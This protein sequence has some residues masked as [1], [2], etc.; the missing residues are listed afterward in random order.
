M[1][2]AS[3]TRYRFQYA[4]KLIC[5]SNVAG[6]SQTTD[7]FLP[8]SYKTAVNIDNPKLRKVTLRKKIASPISISKYFE[9]SLNPDAVERV[10]SRQI[11]DFGF[12]LFHGFKGFRVIES[13]ASMDVNGIIYRGK[14]LRFPVSMLNKSMRENFKPK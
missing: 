7:A 8:G 10:T 9:G 1:P 14:I 12:D 13:M 4:V 3:T 5:A 6:R 2:Q 11:G